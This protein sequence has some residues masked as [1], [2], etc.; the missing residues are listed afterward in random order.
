MAHIGY[1]RV[2]SLQQHT[3]RQLSGVLLDKTFEDK[4]SGKSTER[5][6]FHAMMNYVRD[7]DVLHVHSIDRLSRKTAD[8]L[9]TIETLTQR[10]VVVEFHKEGF[11]TGDDSPVGNL[12]I[13]IFAGIA[14]MERETLLQRQREG[15]EAARAAGRIAGRGKAK[16]IDRPGIL[17]DLS[18]GLSIRKAAEKHHVS[19]KTVMNIKAE[20][21]GA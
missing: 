19:T 8:L 18:Q 5:P 2:S 6:Q 10:G 17:S 12:M 15:Y 1:I 4:A 13:T 14:Q 11:R 7:G 9:E 3:D 21:R 16:N 20:C